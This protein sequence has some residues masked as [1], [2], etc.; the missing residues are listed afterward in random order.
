M[1]VLSYYTWHRIHNGGF[2][3]QQRQQTDE[4]TGPAPKSRVA[5]LCLVGLWVVY[6]ILSQCPESQLTDA[7]CLVLL[8]NPV[9]LGSFAQLDLIPEDMKIALIPWLPGGSYYLAA[10]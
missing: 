10:I 2:L 3:C 7:L 9:Y 8:A 4:R 6:L 5:T 1:L